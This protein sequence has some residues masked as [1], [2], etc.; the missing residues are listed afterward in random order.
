MT[1]A[2][3]QL[4]MEAHLPAKAQLPVGYNFRRKQQAIFEGDGNA[5]EGKEKELGAEFGPEEAV[6]RKRA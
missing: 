4:P 5:E 6:L 3:A 1:A 2:K